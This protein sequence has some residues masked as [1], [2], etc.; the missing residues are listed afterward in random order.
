MYSSDKFLKDLQNDYCS[1]LLVDTSDTLRWLE[2]T[3]NKLSR[4]RKKSMKCF[5]FDFKSLYDSLDPM[6]VKEAITHAMDVSRPEW[7]TELKNWLLAL[8]V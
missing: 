1:D 5:T 4:E 3:N 8:I 6:L 2:E 7:S